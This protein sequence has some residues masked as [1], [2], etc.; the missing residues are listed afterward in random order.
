MKPKISDENKKLFN[1]FFRTIIGGKQVSVSLGDF[2]DNPRKYIGTGISY[3]YENES[4]L[5]KYLAKQGEKKETVV[6]DMSKAKRG[7]AFEND[8]NE[9]IAKEAAKMVEERLRRRERLQKRMKRNQENAKAEAKAKAEAEK[10]E[11]KAKA[12][13]E[14]AEAKAK[15]EAEKAEA[16]KKK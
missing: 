13:A 14:K 16:N 3:L 7:S 10:A 6:L 1:P 15:A 8:M 9:E 12:E 4:E 5:R 11:A 2:L